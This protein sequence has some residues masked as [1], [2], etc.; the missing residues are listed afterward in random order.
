MDRQSIKIQRLI[1]LRQRDV[2]AELSHLASARRDVALAEAELA[3]VRLLLQQALEERRHL[4]YAAMDV[5]TWRSQEEW[6]ETLAL[7]QARAA[8]SVATA[9]VQERRAVARVATAHKKKK[10]AEMLM[11]RLVR[12]QK[13][14]AVRVERKHEDELAQRYAQRNAAKEHS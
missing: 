7:R 4:A 5:T 6:L 13:L 11:E 3:Q 10:Q 12:A 9:K 14:K 2:D 8:N 1:E